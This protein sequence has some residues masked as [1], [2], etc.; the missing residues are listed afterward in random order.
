MLP[1]R[2]ACQSRS[3]FLVIALFGLLA[4]LPKAAAQPA[5]R[6]TGIGGSISSKPANV[7]EEP[8]DSSTQ[9]WRVAG[10]TVRISICVALIAVPLGTVLAIL[11]WRTDV[12]GKIPAQAALALLLF[13][14][15]YLQLAGWEAAVGKLGWV[16][17]IVGDPLL[18]GWSA[19]VFVHAMAAAPWAALIM[20]IGLSHVRR[21]EEETAL[22]DAQGP[23]VFASIVL[24][25]L[26]PY[27]GAAALIAAISAAADMTV[28]NIYLVEP[29][30]HTL[31]E[32]AY[33][34]ITSLPLDAAAPKLIPAVA[35]SAGLVLLT[36]IAFQWVA[37]PPARQVEDQPQPLIYRLRSW[38]W[39]AG[40]MLWLVI[41][42]LVG[43]PLAS[44]AYKAGLA[45]E[46]TPPRAVW[47]PTKM[48]VMPWT[49]MASLKLEAAATLWIGAA[50]AT[51][52]LAVSIGLAELARRSRAMTVLLATLAAVLWSIPGPLVGLALIAL[53]NHDVAILPWIY[54][55]TD[56]AAILAQSIRA[57]PL[58]LLL[59]WHATARFPKAPVESAQLDGAGMGDILLRIIV[60]SRRWALASAWLA[61]LAIA[62]GDLAWSILVLRP[63]VETL[64][65]RIFGDI[66]TGADDRV[67]A[68]GLAISLAYAVASI[69]VLWLARRGGNR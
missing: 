55:R 64:A 8:V 19:V 15:L 31:V 63:G 21:T 52:A 69:A 3:F 7:E 67:A 62:T 12:P 42:I 43:V 14:P 51:V 57:S 37:P 45:I 9:L 50:A 35:L 34:T 10:N 48:L 26:T 59:V 16:T 17:R 24:P 40:L 2:F 61:G 29:G 13:L 41:L 5:A 60:P 1:G 36:I 33:M 56:L 44:M 6:E 22:L 53:L 4:A 66:H 28:T 58:V 23:L 68:A 27:F 65:R 38:R 30:S 54:D 18:D 39:P 11:L 20:S 32:Q 25:Q 49:T 46:G 47:S